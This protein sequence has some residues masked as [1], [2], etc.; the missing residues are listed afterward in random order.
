M[1]L[2]VSPELAEYRNLLPVAESVSHTAA[3]ALGLTREID[4]L[5]LEQWD[6]L[7]KTTTIATDDRTI[8]RAYIAAAGAGQMPPLTIRCRTGEFYD[9][10]EPSSVAVTADE[11]IA[12]ILRRT[13]DPLFSSRAPRTR[14]RSLLVGGC[15]PRRKLFDRRSVSCKPAKRSR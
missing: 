1:E 14:R 15:V 7:L 10:R 12:R 3:A 8:G 11:E 2:A 6:I 9:E 13:G 4:E 5:S